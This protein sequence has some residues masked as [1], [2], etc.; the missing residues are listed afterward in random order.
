MGFLDAEFLRALRA[1][2]ERGATRAASGGHDLFRPI[3]PAASATI[4]RVRWCLCGCGREVSLAGE[5]ATLECERL[6]RG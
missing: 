4:R 3:A 6:V 1:P 5:C 2:R